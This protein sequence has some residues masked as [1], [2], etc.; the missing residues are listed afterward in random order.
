MPP[1]PGSDGSSMGFLGAGRG[2][3]AAGASTGIFG[4]GGGG[5]VIG[6]SAGILGRGRGAASTGVSRAGALAAGEVA[7]GRGGAFSAA[8]RPPSSR[9]IL[10]ILRAKRSSPENEAPSH[11]MAMAT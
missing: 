11:A 6:A 3:G 1:A 10:E 5:E 2:G 9:V 8:G 4:T 7:A